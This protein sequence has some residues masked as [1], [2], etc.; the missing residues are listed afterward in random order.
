MPCLSIRHFAQPVTRRAPR[1]DTNDNKTGQATEDLATGK[2]HELNYLTYQRRAPGPQKANTIHPQL[3]NS[4]GDLRPHVLPSSL[5]AA[6]T[7]AAQAS[8]RKLSFR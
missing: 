8:I 6:S 1:P 4:K 5:Y 7:T 3:R 2:G